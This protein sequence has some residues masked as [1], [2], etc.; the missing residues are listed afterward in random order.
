MRPH[1]TRLD[2]PTAENVSDTSTESASGLSGGDPSKDKNR[3]RADHEDLIRRTS[4]ERDDT[5]RRYDQPIGADPVVP[6]KV[7]KKMTPAV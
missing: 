4:R 5:P 3:N 1:R 6:S 7:Q 2:D